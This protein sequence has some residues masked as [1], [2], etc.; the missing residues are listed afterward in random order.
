MVAESPDVVIGMRLLDLAKRHGFQFRR[1]APGPDG[2]C[3]ECGTPRSGATPSTC[4][5]S[6]RRLVQRHPAPQV[7]PARPRRTA[8]HRP[9]VRGRIERLERHGQ[10]LAALTEFVT[11]DP[12]RSP[13]EPE[14]LP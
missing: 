8:G 1:I 14:A 2:R 6:G 7:L 9:G 4:P 13:V 5:G 11:T 12:G 10:L 3:G